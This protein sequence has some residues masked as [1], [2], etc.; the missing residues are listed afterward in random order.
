MADIRNN[1]DEPVP[2]N[3]TSLIETV[4]W[5]WG[6]VKRRRWWI[7]LPACSVAILSAV[8]FPYLPK[9]YESEATILVVQQRVSP[10]YVTPATTLAVS[11]TVRS[12]TREVLSRPRLLRIIDELGLYP[13]AERTAVLAENMRESVNIEP[14]DP[15]RGTAD[16]SA[17]KLSFSAETPH[18]ALAVTSRLTALFIEE[19]Q[20][21]RGEQA[22][23]TA[24]FLEGQLKIAK[25]KLSEQEEVLRNFKLRNLGRLPQ[26]QQSNVSML[27]ALRTQLRNTEDNLT[28]AATL[29][30]S[31]ESILARNLTQLVS[32]K[33]E[34]L[35]DRTPQHPVVAAKDQEIARTQGLLQR[36]RGAADTS[37]AAAAED[38]AF[39]QLRAQVEAN[40]AEI[41]ALTN[42]KRRIETDLAH[43]QNRLNL[44]PVVESQLTTILRDHEQYNRDYTELLNKQLQSQL[45]ANLE[46]RQ[47]GQ[48]FRL[49][50]PPALPLAPSKPDSRK[51]LLGGLAGGIALGLGLALL[52]ELR[53]RPYT[54]EAE[55]AQKYA[56]P[57]LV[58]I[59][60]MATPQENR[61]RRITRTVEWAAALALLLIVSALDL[62]VLRTPQ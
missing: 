58:S 6:V 5:A 41:T 26:E 54:S 8:V 44:T 52:V 3:E 45:T 23:G 31:L 1:I 9:K 61:R 37:P 21:V 25:A 57:L 40:A 17:F 49:V 50:D 14:L 22:E 12:L 35:R 48:N 39:L 34:L 43:Y 24:A 51:I 16:Y 42:D 11:D 18:L 55:L 60:L 59:P 29:R 4:N 13:G 46:E 62:H 15:A 32:Q 28:R 2:E 36:L 7:F 20:R 53:T 10:V 56:V 27:T 30:D 38:I 47:Q 33:T 19:N